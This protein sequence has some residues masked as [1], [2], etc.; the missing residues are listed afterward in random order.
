MRLM[1]W[2]IG[3]LWIVVGCFGQDSRVLG[4][5]QEA[6]VS[7]QWSVVSEHLFSAKG[8]EEQ[9]SCC[10]NQDFR[11]LDGFSGWVKLGGCWSRRK[12]CFSLLLRPDG[13]GD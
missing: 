3:Y 12:H 2:V 13:N 1:S 10:L 6:V 7:G 9:P 8:R 4:R 11:D 5:G